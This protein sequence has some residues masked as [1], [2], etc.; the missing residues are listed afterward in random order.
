MRIGL[1]RLIRGVSC[2]RDSLGLKGKLLLGSVLNILLLGLIGTL[3]LL[4][5]TSVG[6]EATHLTTSVAENVRHAN[7]IERSIFELVRYLSE[8]RQE[9]RTQRTNE[10]VVTSD[11]LEINETLKKLRQSLAEISFSG[12]QDVI[13]QIDTLS[14]EYVEKFLNVMLRVAVN[15]KNKL[16]LS[17]MAG[18]IQTTLANAVASNTENESIGEKLEQLGKSFSSVLP[19]VQEYFLSNDKRV[20]TSAILT[21]NKS[22]ELLNGEESLEEYTELLEDYISSFE[23]IISVSEKINEEVSN[24]ISP[25]GP[26]IIALSREISNSG[27]QEMAQNGE[28]IKSSV[29]RTNTATVAILGFAVFFG[30]LT[31]VFSARGIAQPILKTIEDISNASSVLEGSTNQVVSE[32]DAIATESTRQIE[33]L[34]TIASSVEEATS[35]ATHNAK[36]SAEANELSREVESVSLKG[37]EATQRMIA[38]MQA[39]NEAANEISDV[40]SFIDEIAFQT[41]LLALN[42]AVEAARAGEA[43]KGFAVVANEVRELAHRSATAAKETSERIERSQELADHG[44]KTCGEVSTFLEQIRS[45][46]VKAAELVV[47]ISVASDEQAS[48]VRNINDSMCKLDQTTQLNS[49]SAMESARAAQGLRSRVKTMEKAVV[50]LEHVV[51][52]NMR[53]EHI[54]TSIPPFTVLETRPM[55]DTVDEEENYFPSM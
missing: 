16:E 23:A 51:Y 55:A 21:V 41:N 49:S 50:R 43:G 8:F 44:I 22:I 11:N 18:E 6:K 14:E 5:A 19:K 54:R 28:A 48:G 32:S 42:A 15:N 13:E 29:A 35:L 36:R 24:T 38:E 52:G 27:W 53:D 20:A 30:I 9:M 10:S 17:T 47:Q 39:I 31:A 25:I 34:S 37:A 46:S 33:L 26:R 1:T 2:M 7:E 4:S 12:H 40:I 45:N 3:S